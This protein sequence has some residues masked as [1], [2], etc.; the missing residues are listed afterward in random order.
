ML[1]WNISYENFYASTLIT[2]IK[3]TVMVKGDQS[4]FYTIQVTK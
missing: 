3:S 1:A 4:G 2:D